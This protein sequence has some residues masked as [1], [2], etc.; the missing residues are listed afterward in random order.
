M[1]YPFLETLFH[2]Y[3]SQIENK[4]DALIIFTHW[5]LISHGFQ[6]LDGNQKTELLPNDWTQRPDNS[7]TMEYTKNDIG[8]NLKLFDVEGVFFAH[9]FRNKQGR[10]V[11]INFSVNDHVHENYKEFQSAYKNLNDLKKEFHEKI[12]SL[13]NGGSDSN[14]TNDSSSSGNTRTGTSTNQQQPSSGRRQIPDDPLIDP[15]AAGR[16]PHP[17][18]GGWGPMPGGYGPGAGAYGS[19]DL[20][21][22][23]RNT[24]GGGMNMD[25]SMFQPSM[26]PPMARFQPPG[27]QRG[28]F[29]V[30]PFHEPN[31]DHLPMPGP[32]LDD[33]YN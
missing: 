6:R 12:E 29:G 19:S 9:L 11:E 31:A 8:Y 30:D 14:V 32:H 28:P 15:L 25:P 17:Y 5:C 10:H 16:R 21:P 2:T 4:D 20:D 27:P 33:M 3:R 7:I 26:R 1:S 18:A 13:I 22:F 24:R 23:G